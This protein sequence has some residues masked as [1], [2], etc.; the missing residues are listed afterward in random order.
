MDIVENLNE[1]QIE[2]LDLLYQSVWFTQGRKIS[3]IERM[4]ENSYLTLAFL[5]NEKLVY[6]AITFSEL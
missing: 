4:L 2:Q 3:D 5:E 1:K 6:P